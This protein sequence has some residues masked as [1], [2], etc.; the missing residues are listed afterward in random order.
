MLSRTKIKARIRLKTNPDLAKTIHLAMNH[1]AWAKIA[2]VL[3]GSTKHQ[4]RVSLSTIE[5][6]SSIG[7]TIIIPGKVLSQGDL[8]KKIKICALAISEQAR[9]KLK[10]TKSEFLILGDEIKKNPKAEG[11]KVIS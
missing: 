3:S 10:T 1:P 9:E 5:N 6:N 7:D 8:T 2:K 4:S 11:I